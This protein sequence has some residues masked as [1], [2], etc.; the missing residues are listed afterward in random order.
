MKIAIPSNDQQTISGHFG[1]T[2]GFVI[3]YIEDGKVI[4]KEY[5]KNNFTEHAQGQHHQENHQH[6]GNHSHDGIFEALGD[7][8][9]VIAGGMGQRLYND[10]AQKR[11]QI[12]VTKEKNIDK[13][14]DLFIE[15]N[16][17]NNSDKCCN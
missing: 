16:L 10:F 15:N 6:G 2:A 7:C 1:R 12:F 3:I 5:K 9:I 13:A 11:I 4:N 14:I 8:K 17:D